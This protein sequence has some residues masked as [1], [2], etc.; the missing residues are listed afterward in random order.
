MCLR[1]PFFNFFSHLSQSKIVLSVIC[2][3]T[4]VTFFPFNRKPLEVGY[5]V[6]LT[7]IPV[8]NILLTLSSV[9][10]R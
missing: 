3:I 6:L 8:H 9:E 10:K 4:Y 1:N 5:C 7:F 2:S